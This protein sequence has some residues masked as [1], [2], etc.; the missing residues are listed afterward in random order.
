MR[1]ILISTLALFGVAGVCALTPRA[2]QIATLPC[3]AFH[4]ILDA[5]DPTLN[6][7]FCVGECPDTEVICEVVDTDPSSQNDLWHCGCPGLTD[8]QCQAG[9]HWWFDGEGNHWNAGCYGGTSCDQQTGTCTSP[10]PGTGSLDWKC[11]PEPP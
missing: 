2:S 1:S 7:L 6:E 5:N 8:V 3:H 9:I 4:V 10:F 11:C